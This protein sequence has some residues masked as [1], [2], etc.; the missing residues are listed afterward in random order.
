[1]LSRTLSLA[2]VTLLIAGFLAVPALAQNQNLEA[3]K[4]P[5]Q[6]FAG[7]C[8]A[9][10]KGPRGLL[11]TVPPSSLQGYLRQH[12]TTSPAMASLLAGFLVSNGAADTRHTADQPKSGR[13]EKPETRPGAGPDQVDRFGRR[14]R[15]APPQDAAKLESE[16]RDASKPSDGSSEPGRQGRNAKRFVRPGEP[17]V[18]EGETPA[19]VS[20]QRGSAQQ[21]LSRRGKP[22]AEESAKSET[23]KTDHGKE[24]PAKTE[25]GREE[26]SKN[27]AAKEP[28]KEAAKLEDGKA[29]GMKAEGMK[30]EG[31]KSEGGKSEGGPDSS[32]AEVTKSDTDKGAS[33]S[34]KSES[35]QIEIPNECAEPETPALRPDS[36]PPESTPAAVATTG[37]PEPV[38]TPAAVQPKQP[39]AESPQAV[40]AS[41]P[42]PVA[43]A[44]PPAPPISR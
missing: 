4:S 41:A 10:H 5:S 6:I 3:G 35:S 28:A 22:N 18:T 27:E 26:A 40:A 2:T 12:Y 44:G 11:K 9:C 29:E 31:V 34:G 19:Q 13:G 7:T 16:P 24:E 43:P 33:D 20:R 15:T 23:A 21:K 1:M 14:L 17:G 32:K 38:V 39:P 8:T 36:L 37:T 25:G 30:S 42:P